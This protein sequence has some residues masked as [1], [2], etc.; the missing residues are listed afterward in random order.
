MST[1]ETNAAARPQA[2]DNAAAT[3]RLPDFW[4][5]TPGSWFIFIESKF[6]VK[7]ITD[8]ASKFDLVVGCLPRESIRQVIDVLE[9]LDP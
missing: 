3:L 8:E 4:P 2:A 7:N 5:D 6:R 9:W 1:P